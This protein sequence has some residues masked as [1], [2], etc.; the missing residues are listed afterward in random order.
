MTGFGQLVVCQI[1]QANPDPSEVEDPGKVIG[2]GIEVGVG[3][4][5]GS[6]ARVT[7]MDG[8]RVTIPCWKASYN[9]N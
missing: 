8:P 4:G 3:Q 2:A 6:R 7:S 9:N 1:Y 5:V